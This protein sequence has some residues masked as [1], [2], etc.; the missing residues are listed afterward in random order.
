[1]P[2]RMGTHTGRLYTPD[3]GIDQL[4]Q[5]RAI[6]ESRIVS[7]GKILHE[8]IQALIDEIRAY[9]IQSQASKRFILCRDEEQVLGIVGM[10]EIL[11]DD[12]AMR[13][14]SQYETN[15]TCESIFYWWWFYKM[16]GKMTRGK[17]YGNC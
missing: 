16:S 7:E 11:P 13:T 15:R 2:M 10:Q 12:K 8:E 9:I 6:L 5:I 17:I 14:L 3:I 4:G 1:M